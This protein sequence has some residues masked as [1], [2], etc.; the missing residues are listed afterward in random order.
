MIHIP[1]LIFSLLYSQVINIFETII[2]I[3]GFWKIKTP[4]PICKGD[5]KNDG[6]HLL[7]ALL[8]FLPFIVITSS[9]FKALPWAWLVWF[10]NDTTWHFWSVH[11]KYWTKW[12][13][14]YFDPHSEV[15]LWYARF[16]IV[17]VKV[18]PKRMFYITIFRLLLMPFL[19]ILL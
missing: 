15:T 4:F 19:F 17:K 7:L 12:I 9:F 1:L 14:F 3:K 8:Y 10:L 5:V 18:S 6:Y 13:I 2:W 16:F 11:P